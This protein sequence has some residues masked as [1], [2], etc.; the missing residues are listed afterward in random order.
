MR[1]L[2]SCDATLALSSPVWQS[3]VDGAKNTLNNLG[4]VATLYWTPPPPEETSHC[5][6]ALTM[7]SSDTT[8]QQRT[9]RLF[10]AVELSEEVKTRLLN[11]QS[12]I[13]GLKWIPA[14]NLHLTLRFIGQVPQERGALIQQSLRR[15]QTDAF[16]LVVSGLGL[17]QRRTGG[18]LWAGVKN[19][20]A[21][22]K[23]KRQ[24]DEALWVSAGPD[25]SE[26]EFSPHITLSRLKKPISLSLRHLVQEH[27]TVR[28]GETAVTDFTLFRSLLH[29]SGAIYMPAVRYRLGVESEDTTLD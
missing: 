13:S 21:L 22:I 23:L 2:V 5:R 16:R 7:Q 14:A 1:A 18:I 6:Q 19:D 3:F 8:D 24:V 4:S 25:L 9:D 17:F 15:V 10:V 26:K 12:R 11:L 20:P 29:P 28:F 27:A